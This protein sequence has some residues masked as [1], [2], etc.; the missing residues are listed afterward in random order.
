MFFSVEYIL[1]LRAFQLISI[2]EVYFSIYE[3]DFDTDKPKV[4]SS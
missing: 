3:Q 4:L 2:V 1:S